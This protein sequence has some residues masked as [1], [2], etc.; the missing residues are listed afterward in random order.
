MESKEHTKGPW[1][2]EYSGGETQIIANG[3]CIMSDMTYYPWNPENPYDWPLI[4]QSPEMLRLLK[5]ILDL[6]DNGGPF[7]GEIY[8]DRVE[9]AFYD[10]R[11]AVQKAEEI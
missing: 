10:I 6:E 11:K 7:G 5:E 1:V 2:L 3:K 8:Q 9:K 4:S